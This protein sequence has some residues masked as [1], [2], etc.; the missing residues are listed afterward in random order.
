[1]QHTLQADAAKMHGDHTGI[2]SGCAASEEQSLARPQRAS[3]PHMIALPC[4]AATTPVRWI[5]RYFD[6]NVSDSQLRNALYTPSPHV[7]HCYP[8]PTSLCRHLSSRAKALSCKQR[9][10]LAIAQCC[11]MPHEHW[12]EVWGPRGPTKV[13]ITNG[14]CD[15]KHA[16]VVCLWGLRCRCCA[17]TDAAYACKVACLLLGVVLVVARCVCVEQSRAHHNPMQ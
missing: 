3:E 11:S 4:N 10:R 15:M 7:F 1:M 12:A 2:V 6:A 8:S 17:A 13:T 14:D 5:A 9:A 16:C